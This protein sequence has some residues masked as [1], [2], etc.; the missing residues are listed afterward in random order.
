MESLKQIIGQP[1][2]DIALSG[3]ILFISIMA[4]LFLKII[5]IN[6]ISR[7]AAKTSWKWDDPVVKYLRNAILFWCI[8]LGIYLAKDVW[9]LHISTTLNE[10]LNKS[11]IAL[12][13]LSLILTLANIVTALIGVYGEK[14]HQ[15]VPLT[16][17]TQS[18]VKILIIVVGALMVLSALGVSITPL[19]TTLGIGGLAVA[20]ALQ[21]TLSNLFAGFYITVA[22]NIRV[23]DFIK[24]ESGQEGFVVDIGWRVTKIRLLS[25]SLVLI[26]NS[27][28]SQSIIVNY[29]LP[30]KEVAAI[31]ELGVHYN[32]DLEF[33]E[34]ETMTIAKEIQAT[35]PSAVKSFE[36]ILLYNKFDSSS[37]N[38]MVIMR[39]TDVISSYE[40]K[41]RFIKKLHSHY[42]EKGIVIP[43]PIT[44][45]NLEQE[46]ANLS[47]TSA[48][49]TNA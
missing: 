9:K 43:F 27:K 25:N 40:L 18:L 37:I 47:L 24:L 44:A 2:F 26:P 48:I 1:W 3:A 33:V 49:K 22:K 28:L 6:Y 41:H 13:G 30:D 21:E 23:G 39:A 16:N 46:K 20:L 32:S 45:I 17:L 19:L 36:P 15:A 38:F 14:I 11:L 34:K 35:F 42:K 12:F 5:V 7:M 10:V 8:L 4:G 31:I 29:F